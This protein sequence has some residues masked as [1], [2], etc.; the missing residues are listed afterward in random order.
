MNARVID[1]VEEAIAYLQSE[2]TE[3]VKIGGDLAVFGASIYGE[4]Y[5]GTIPAALA[6]GLW[7]LQ[8][9]LYRA[10]AF[11]LYG[12]DNYKRLTDE[13]K[14]NFELIFEVREGSSEILATLEGFFTELGKG[15][16]NMDSGHKMKTLVA[17]AAALTLTFGY[18][19]YN[20]HQG[21][22]VEVQAEAEDKKGMRELVT[23][24]QVAQQEQLRVLAGLV[25]KDEGGARFAKAAEN[26][27]R[28]VV[29]GASDADKIRINKVSFDR[30]AIADIT[31][32]AA[33]ET[34]RAEIVTDEYRVVRGDSRDGGVT[35]FWLLHKDGTEFSGIVVDEDF[36]AKG[37]N[38]LWEAFRGRGT[39]NLEL[40]M[41]TVRG[42]IRNASIV[43]VV[44]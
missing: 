32:R 24:Q 23:A 29:K 31:Q 16:Q 3:D 18:Q 4:N 9:E 19:T 39:V 33:K 11:T 20:D 44:Q 21:K 41:T 43:R 40:N 6:R 42:Q 34:A 1:T 8:E 38:Q 27:T 5:H 2:G 36:D 37:L 30:D 7:E 35:R 28:A 10:V 15:F 13:Q 14:A 17:I 12:G 26:G 22:L 25:Q